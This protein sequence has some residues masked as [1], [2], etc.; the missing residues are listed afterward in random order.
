MGTDTEFPTLIWCQTEESV[1]CTWSGSTIPV[2]L[3]SAVPAQTQDR[4]TAVQWYP[5]ITLGINYALQL[6]WP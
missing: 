3:P 4:G 6:T 5:H 1:D 2:C